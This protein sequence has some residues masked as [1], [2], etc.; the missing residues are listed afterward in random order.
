MKVK[1]APSVYHP[2]M[3]MDV[4]DNILLVKNFLVDCFKVEWFCH[5]G[6]WHF[7][8][9]PSFLRQASAGYHNAPNP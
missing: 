1:S 4:D 2:I 9:T 3:T 7:K 8:K 6:A 5:A